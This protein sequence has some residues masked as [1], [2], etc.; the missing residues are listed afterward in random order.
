MKF[1]FKITLISFG[2]YIPL[3]ALYFLVHLYLA[4]DFA[5]FLVATAIFAVLYIFVH[6]KYSKPFFKQHPKLDPQNFEFNTAA[7]VV[8]AIA[9]I[10]LMGLVIFNLY[11]KSPV[12]YILA[13][14]LYYS[15]I[16][17]FKTYRRQ[18]G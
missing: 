13:F 5:A 18:A 2:P 17:G 15:I 1:N 14:G 4:S 11:P 9:T 7:N 12:G 10:V 6:Y 3:I 16:N 8:F